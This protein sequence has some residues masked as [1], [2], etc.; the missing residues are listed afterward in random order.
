MVGRVQKKPLGLLSYTPALPHVQ[1]QVT[2]GLR[3]SGGFEGSFRQH[4]GG[5]IQK[6]K[7]LFYLFI[8]NEPYFDNV[9]PIVL[10]R[11]IL[12]GSVFVLFSSIMFY[13]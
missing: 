7:E 5:L 6:G 8:M 2:G 11:T 1:P 13:F 4:A 12:I 10:Y 3:G 9:D